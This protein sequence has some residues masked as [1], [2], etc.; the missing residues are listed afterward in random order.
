MT[1]TSVLKQ[2]E[3]FAFIALALLVV[4]LLVATDRA[5]LLREV[6]TTPPIVVLSESEQAYRFELGSADVSLSFA[7]QIEADI[8]PLLDSLSREHKTDVIEV[9]GHTDAV[10]VGTRSTLDRTLVQA[11]EERVPRTVVSAGS[12]VDL[13]MMRALT[14][15]QLLRQGKRRGLLQSVNRFVPYSAGQ[16]ILPDGGLAA[17][18]ANAPDRARRRIEI[19]LRRTADMRRA[20][21]TSVTVAPSTR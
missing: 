16:M 13:G 9:I 20:A 14:V 6:Q 7:R 3:M 4:L 10:P 15:I 12:N 5:R 1:V 2:S 8:V 11:Y 19:R 17:S 18:D 21:P